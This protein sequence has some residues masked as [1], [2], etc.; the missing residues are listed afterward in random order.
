MLL[1]V[2]ALFALSGFAFAT[3]A[4][5]G[6]ITNVSITIAGANRTVGVN[7]TYVIQL[8]ASDWYGGQAVDI[9][10]I[11][12]TFPT[13]TDLS[14]AF[15]S[16]QLEDSETS[17]RS[18]LVSMFINASA[19]NINN[20]N[21][22]VTVSSNVINI[23]LV[24][25]TNATFANH[26]DAYFTIYVAGVNTTNS[27]TNQTANG[28]IGLFSITAINSTSTGQWGSTTQVN[29]SQTSTG[30][31]GTNGTSIT[32]VPNWPYNLTAYGG[33]TQ[34]MGAGNQ[35][36]DTLGSTTYANI[37]ALVQDLYGNFVAGANTSFTYLNESTMTSPSGGVLNATLVNT[38]IGEDGA[39][40]FYTNATGHASIGIQM[41]NSTANGTTVYSWNASVQNNGTN[42][43]VHFTATAQA[44]VIDYYLLT[45]SSATPSLNTQFSVVISSYDQFS[46]ING[47]S[48]WT[49]PRLSV[50]AANWQSLLYNLD[51][52]TTYTAYTGTAFDFGGLSSGN[53]TVYFKHSYNDGL[54]FT[55][56][57]DTNGATGTGYA[58]IVGMQALSGGGGG[59]WSG[60][61]STATPIPT[62]T[63]QPTAAPT[64]PSVAPSEPTEPV[65]APTVAPTIAPTAT[66]TP[67]EQPVAGG[68]DPIA[69]GA[70][71]IIVLGGAYWYFF[72][73]KP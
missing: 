9:Q 49:S 21:T 1:S 56:L 40:T 59:S 4:G 28:E 25:A 26:T 52:S 18:G 62:G 12:V 31:N 11:S 55:I 20:T 42:P 33:N 36:G 16:P 2:V 3:L 58:T 35:S 51:G 23:A 41:A 69:G 44:N 22:T 30:G 48:A 71:V 45:P 13:G 29:Y 73:R 38:T 60:T 70:V 43:K 50:S 6:T 63:P 10:N 15:I 67:V 65:V 61:T 53:D 24:N 47:T 37:T 17:P 8:N 54:T 19:S 32:L 7:S 5:N 27:F 39:G 34:T 14:T 66:P 57:S 68:I 46:N 72:M 64:E